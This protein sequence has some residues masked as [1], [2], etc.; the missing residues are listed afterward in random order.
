MPLCITHSRSS[1]P[2]VETLHSNAELPIQQQ[3]SCPETQVRELSVKAKG[4]ASPVAEIKVRFPLGH[5]GEDDFR[6]R[7]TGA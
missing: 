1:G 7:G 6:L 4:R 2:I 3:E 5:E